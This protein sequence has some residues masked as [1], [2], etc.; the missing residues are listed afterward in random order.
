MQEYERIYVLVRQIPRAKVTTYGQLGIM[1]GISDSRIIGEAMNAS[2]GLPW[3]RVINSKGEVSI[4]GA[5]GAKQRSL[6]EEEG[7]VFENNR[8]DLGT[9]GWVPDPDWLLAHGYKVPP[10][11]PQEKDKKKDKEEGQQL[12]LF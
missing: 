4:R 8:V 6:L 1:C 9:Y 5:T 2:S 10:P 7:V 3:Q 12:N 11:F